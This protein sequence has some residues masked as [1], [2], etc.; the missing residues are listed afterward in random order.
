MKHRTAEVNRE[1]KETQ[2]VVKIDLDGRGAYEIG[3][4]MGFLDHMLTHLSKHSGIDL[5]IRAKGD[6]EVDDHHTVED[7]GICLGQGLQEALGDKRGIARFGHSVVPME[8]AKAEVTIDL[9]GRPYLIYRVKYH[10][11]KIGDFD[12][13]C[14]EEFFRAFSTS[15]R[16]NLHI[17]VPYGNNSHHIAEAIFKAV[18]QALGQA[19]RVRGGEIP[20]TKGIL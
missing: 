9:S 7:V 16:M 4:G 15:S 5:E 14:V 19:V 13:E 12:V 20:S 18:G 11:E 8:D 2:I 1:T 17:E 3:T 6:L 10:T